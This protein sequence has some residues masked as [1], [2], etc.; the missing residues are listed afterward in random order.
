[1]LGN[2]ING[3]DIASILWQN[4]RNGESRLQDIKWYKDSM[5]WQRKGN[6]SGPNLSYD[7]RMIL[8][9][10]SKNYDCSC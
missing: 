6:W 9:V 5:L 1:M 2:V 8:H 7:A 10:L 3:L 4:A